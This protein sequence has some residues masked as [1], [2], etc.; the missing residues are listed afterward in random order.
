M[1]AIENDLKKD[2]YLKV[3]RNNTFQQ[4]NERK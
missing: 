1:N 2:G 3:A 4:N